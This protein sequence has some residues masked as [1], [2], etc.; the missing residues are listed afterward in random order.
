MDL[1]NDKI[2]LLA[3]MRFKFSRD[4]SPAIIEID[5]FFVRRP[6]Y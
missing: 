5:S 4:V 2:Y 1:A 3:A 6:R